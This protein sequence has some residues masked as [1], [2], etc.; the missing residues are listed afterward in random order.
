MEDINIEIEEVIVRGNSLILDLVGQ[1]IEL[2][3]VQKKENPYRSILSSSITLSFSI[4]ESY[5]NYISS[6]IIFEH[7]KDSSIS[8]IQ[9]RLS[10][11][12]LDLLL[13]KKSYF[14]IKKLE[15]KKAS[16]SYTRIMDKLIV[17]PKLLAKAYKKDINI[18]KSVKMW[19]HLKILRESR[20]DISHPKF[21]IEKI[22][23]ITDLGEVPLS[24]KPAYTINPKD[25]LNGLIA[26]RWYLRLTGKL[27]IDV[28]KGKFSSFNLDIIDIFLTRLIISV[29]EKYSIQAKNLRNEINDEFKFPK[30]SNEKLDNVMSILTG[31]MG[32]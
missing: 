12:E 27:L 31:S 11:I 20:D 1:L 7:K 10:E 5:L 22:E 28:F 26:I 3:D 24:T 14:D 4:L 17:I 19:E 21:D 15:V 9:N 8:L 13:E 6:L 23:P 2:N 18:D 32:D 29:D 25:Y 16:N 30:N